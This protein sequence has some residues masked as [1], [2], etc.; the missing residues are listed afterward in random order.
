V[1][2]ADHPTKGVLSEYGVSECDRIASAKRRPWPTRDYCAMEKNKS[3]Q[4]KIFAFT[5]S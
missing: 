3:S 4:E 1:G 5:V 2:R